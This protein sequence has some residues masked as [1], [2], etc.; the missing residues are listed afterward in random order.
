VDTR[1]HWYF[2]RMI[3]QT[4]YMA[5][6]VGPFFPDG[7]AMRTPPGG[8]V[9]RGVIIETLVLTQGI[10]VGPK[11]EVRPGGGS[12]DF[13]FPL[14][15]EVLRLGQKRFDITCAACHGV[16]GDAAS[17]VATKMQ[18]R[19]PPSLHQAEIRAYTPGQLFRVVTEGYGLMPSYATLLNWE[20]R[21]AVVAYVKAL[22]LSQSATVGTL[23]AAVRGEIMELL[24]GGSQ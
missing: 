4:K 16:A 19:P 18:L 5:F 20:E 3:R 12:A 13:P 8:T 7:R 10:A 11:L 1:V 22:Q 6:Q 14:T 21:W 24:A 9:P 17:T 2:E 15:D 23:P